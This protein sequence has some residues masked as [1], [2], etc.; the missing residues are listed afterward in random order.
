MGNYFLDLP[1]GLGSDLEYGVLGF[2]GF[3]CFYTQALIKI[4]PAADNMT[5]E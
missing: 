2:K 1:R 3:G 5:Y 4:T